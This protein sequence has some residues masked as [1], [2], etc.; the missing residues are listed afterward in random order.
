MS[1][2]RLRGIKERKSTPEQ[3]LGRRKKIRKGDISK[4]G[5]MKIE[6]TREKEVD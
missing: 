5:G 1:S 3:T 6:M 4:K 2:Y